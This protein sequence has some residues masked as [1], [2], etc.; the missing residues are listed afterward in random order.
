MITTCRSCGNYTVLLGAEIEGARTMIKKLRLLLSDPK[1][2]ESMRTNSKGL[3]AL[4]MEADLLLAYAIGEEIPDSQ[5][6]FG[7]IEGAAA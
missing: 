4:Q 3:I 5:Y 7:L 2:R 6:S 1:T